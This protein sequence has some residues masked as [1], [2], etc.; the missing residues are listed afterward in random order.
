MYK[1]FTLALSIHPIELGAHLEKWVSHFSFLRRG[2]SAFM[3]LPG[4]ASERKYETQ[5]SANQLKFEIVL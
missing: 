4:R 2:I 5:S 1:L 3:V